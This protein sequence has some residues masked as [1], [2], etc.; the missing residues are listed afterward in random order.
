M[1]RLLVLLAAAAMVAAP[2]VAAED[3]EGCKDSTVLS[4]MSSCN[5]TECEKKDFDAF[6]FR[7][8]WDEQ[9][10]DYKTKTV[11]G[12]KE[13][14]TY[15]CAETN[16]L[17]QIA[18][19]AEAALKRAAFTVVYSGKGGND[20]PM[21]TA[22]KGGLWVHVETWNNGGTPSYT[23]TIVRAKEMEQSM[24]AGADEFER[25]IS[26]T[27]R[28]AIYGI[29]FDTGKATI[30]ASSEA[31][32]AEVAKLLQKN[33]AWKIEIGGHTDNV[34]AKD[35]NAKL[36]QARAEAVKSWLVG[37]GIAAPRLTA[38]GFGDTKPVAGNTSDEG[39]SKNR[40]VE[41]V[42]L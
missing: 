34:G 39:R 42:K 21:V 12:A 22:H 7:T 2:L 28:A 27:G 19:N 41:L 4:R 35:T 40:R 32:L 37:H 31:T 25:Q 29:L 15:E 6:D 17:L 26:A 14:I 13:V 33:S 36:S 5:I 10:G 20:Q 11:E 30:T 24:E 3:A 16:S 1:N 18:R 9:V 38:R 8:A 23:Q